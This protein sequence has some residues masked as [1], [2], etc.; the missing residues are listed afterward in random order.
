M[1]STELKKSGRCQTKRN[2]TTNT[3]SEKGLH[4]YA[5]IIMKDAIRHFVAHGNYSK[6]NLREFIEDEIIDLNASYLFASNHTK[7][8]FIR[9][10]I[11]LFDRYY[12]Q[13]KRFKNKYSYE[14][15]PAEKSLNCFGLMVEI[16]PDIVFRTN[17]S[18]EVIK[19][20]YGKPTITQA[21]STLDGSAKTSL[22][23]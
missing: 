1:K 20:K 7:E 4:F 10:T 3:E 8:S 15:Y 6:E 9:Q 5:S 19:Y 11:L 16:T 18:I 2:F 13:E 12:T 22:E 14:L 21:G 17:D 23:L